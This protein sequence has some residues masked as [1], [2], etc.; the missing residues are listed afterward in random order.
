MTDLDL[1]RGMT[2]SQRF[3]FQTEMLKHRKSF[4]V[5]A[6]LCFAGFFG[7]HRFYLGQVGLGLLYACTLGLFFIGAL[8][9]LLRIGSIVERVN[10]AKAEEI[11]A[12]IM[13]LDA[14]PPGASKTPEDSGPP[15]LARR[16]GRAAGGRR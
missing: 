4:G 11:A 6:V 9:D 2:D 13:A 14:P 5:A 12:Q 8:L 10:R 16:L 7:L 15:S 1:M 3:L